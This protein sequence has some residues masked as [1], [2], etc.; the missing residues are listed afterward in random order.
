LCCLDELEVLCCLDELEVLCCL[1]ELEVL[2]CLDELGVLCCLDELQDSKG[3][4]SRFGHSVS[5]NVTVRTATSC[6]LQKRD[7]SDIL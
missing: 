3:K 2:C 1:D 7:V 5:C 6:G 4:K